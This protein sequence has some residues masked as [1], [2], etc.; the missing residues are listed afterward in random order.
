MAVFPNADNLQGL[1]RHRYR[2]PFSHHLLFGLADTGTGRA[3]LTDLLPTVTPAAA[4]AE[5][6]GVAVAIGVT[7]TGLASLGVPAEV[8]ATF[9]PEFLE[10]PV[11]TS[12]GDYGQDSPEH[13]WFGQLK[14]NDIHLVV[15]LWAATAAEADVAADRVRTAAR[16]RSAFELLPGRDGTPLTGAFLPG[17]RLHFGYRDGLTEPAIAWDVTTPA[18]ID[19]RHVVLGYSSD[20]VPSTPDTGLA[21][22]LA[23]DGTYSFFRWIYQDVA[24]FNRWLQVEAARLGPIADE[25]REEWLAAKMM[26]RWRD[27]TPLALSPNHPDPTLATQ[28]FGFADDRQGLRCPVSAHIRVVNPR[29]QELNPFQDVP[30]VLRRG[31]PC[32]PPLEGLEDDGVER[33]LVGMFFC[34][35]IR[36]QCYR[37]LSWMNRNDFSPVFTPGF[38]TQDPLGSRSM[39]DGSRAFAIPTANGPVTV[40]L[41]T[42]LRTR[43]TAFFLLPGIDG[44]RRLSQGVFS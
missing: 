14:T 27:G 31:T 26:G 18:G 13:W 37:L 41:S 16:D 5:P 7:C 42:F 33:G 30:V 20:T 6:A 39:P 29:D 23:R 25:N 4:G 19:F 38:D 11:A 21:A 1:V 8:Q 32:G 22:E 28:P 24:A 17:G 9:S 3:F 44:L 35:N 15:H 10:G 40:Q 36:Q 43:G 12:L 34:V 2:R